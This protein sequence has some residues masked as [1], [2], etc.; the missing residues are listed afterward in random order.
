MGAFNYPMGY[1]CYYTVVG[2]VG[3][4]IILCDV[5]IVV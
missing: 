2:I 1:D 3:I 5:D 4:I